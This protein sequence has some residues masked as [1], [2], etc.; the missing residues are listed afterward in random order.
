MHW[1]FT[2][3]VLTQIFALFTAP[4]V[5]LR[6]PK[7]IT[8]G[9]LKKFSLLILYCVHSPMLLF[10]LKTCSFQNTAVQAHTL[11]AKGPVLRSSVPPPESAQICNRWN[12]VLNLMPSLWVYVII[13]LV[14][15]KHVGQMFTSIIFHIYQHCNFNSNCK[16]KK[17]TLNYIACKI[18][19]V[20]YVNYK[21]MFTILVTW[22]ITFV[23]H[24]ST[25][26]RSTLYIIP[27]NQHT[28]TI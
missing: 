23:K 26:L 8:A 4:S 16:E 18:P 20:V 11:E 6:N 21:E 1:K 24:S 12:S 2:V 5:M 19:T 28:K 10:V 17:L 9:L 14:S 22:Q 27:Q 15:T 13:G 3:Q 25:N 7:F